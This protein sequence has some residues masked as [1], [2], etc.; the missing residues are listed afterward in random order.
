MF[1]STTALRIRWDEAAKNNSTAART[2]SGCSKVPG[3]HLGVLNGCHVSYAHLEPEAGS[4]WENLPTD[5]Q[6]RSE[7]LFVY[8]STPV[9][10][11]NQ[12]DSALFAA[13]VHSNAPEGAKHLAIG[14]HCLS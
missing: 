8:N 4:R 5:D 7:L 2:A 1:F 9:T 6:C 3:E 13:S 12:C 10:K 11:K 14:P